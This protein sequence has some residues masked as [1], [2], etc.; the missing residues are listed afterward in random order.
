PKVKHTAD[1]PAPVA[2]RSDAAGRHE[3]LGDRIVRLAAAQA[4]KPYVYGAAGPD[5][6]DCSGLTQFI[7][8]Q[9]GILLP[10][11]AD[12]QS[13]A[14][15]PVDRADMRPGDLLFFGRRG[16]VYHVAIY[17]GDN[18]MWTAPEPGKRVQLQRIW[19]NTYSVGRAW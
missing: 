14:V 19:D 8:R 15:R 13:R 16:H 17:A 2:A 10:R 11:T 18:K 1:R 9:L 12:A 3:S 4:G 7:H 5:R 6:F